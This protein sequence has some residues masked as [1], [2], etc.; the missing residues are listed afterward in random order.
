MRLM[1]YAPIDWLD[2]VAMRVEG[3]ARS[4]VNA[5]LQDISKGHRPVF[6]TWAQFRD[7]MVQRFEPV[8][9]VE[10]ARKQLR[11]LRQTGRVSGYVQKFRE[12]QYWLPGMTDEEAFHTFISGLQPHLQEHVGGCYC[13][14]PVS[15][16]L[17][18]RRRGHDGKQRTQNVPK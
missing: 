10:E 9:E 1:C 5:V 17:S 12:L 14:G 8:N 3:A 6:R 11:A 16:G 15:G 18:W 2:V 4:W 7:A 13:Q